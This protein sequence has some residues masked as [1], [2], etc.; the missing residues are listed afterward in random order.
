MLS[1]FGLVPIASMAIN[2]GDVFG[3]L[4]VEEIGKQ[5]SNRRAFAVC[6]CS[7]GSELKAIRFDAL[8]S[9]ITTSCGCFQREQSTTHGLTKSPH[10]KRWG[11]M[12]SRCTN[13]SDAAYKDYGGRGIKVCDRWLSV[14][15]FIDDLPAGYTDGVEI[16][17]IDNDGDYEPGNVRW[18]SAKA[19]SDNRRSARRL[20]FNG[21]TQ[22]L[23]RWAIE[24]GVN[25]GTLKSRLDDSGWTLERALTEPAMSGYDVR[26][27]GISTRWAGH[28]TPPKKAPRALKR[29]EYKGESLSINEL[30]RRTGITVKLLRK[31]LCERGWPIDKAVIP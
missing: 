31:R 12:I 15:Q 4:V 6:R 21:K 3:R 20:T 11:H 5:A 17:R 8:L 29:F 27:L 18:S 2:L 16:D 25:Q 14:E 30:S 1:Q 23:S 13:P 22:S 28:E 19:N 9:G 10:Y 24:I 7:C 26:A